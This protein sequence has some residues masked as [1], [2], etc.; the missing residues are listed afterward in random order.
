MGALLLGRSARLQLASSSS[1]PRARRCG[2]KLVLDQFTVGASCGITKPAEPSLHEQCRYTCKAEAAPQFH[3]WH[4]VSAT[5]AWNAA[6]AVIVKDL[7]HPF[8]GYSYRP[9][10]ATITQNRAHYCLVDP[11]LSTQRYFLACQANIS[12]Y[13]LCRPLEQRHVGQIPQ[14]SHKRRT[15]RNL[16]AKRSII[17]G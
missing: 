17:Y 11:V 2:Q 7:Q 13:I 5:F 12:L 1:A 14:K 3:G 15:R 16:N 4:T 6:D 9:R 8:V 10:L